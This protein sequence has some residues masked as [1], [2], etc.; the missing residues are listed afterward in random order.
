[1]R[2]TKHMYC[3]DAPLADC[4][5]RSV[6]ADWKAQASQEVM[7]VA[8]TSHE[9]TLYQNTCFLAFSTA[10]FREVTTLQ[11]SISKEA[12]VAMVTPDAKTVNRLRF[13]QCNLRIEGR[14]HRHLAAAQNPKVDVVVAIRVSNQGA[15]K[16]PSR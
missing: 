13:R 16:R 10:G 4:E 5:S 12:P 9:N 1:M 3:K 7:V 2:A 14:S 15:C 11:G 8:L 6:Y